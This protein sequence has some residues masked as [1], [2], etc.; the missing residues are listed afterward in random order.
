MEKILMVGAGSTKDPGYD[1]KIGETPFRDYMTERGIHVIDPIVIES[2][3]GCPDLMDRYSRQLQERVE[4]GDRVVSVL[5][6]GLLFGLPSLQATQVTF[7]IISVPLDMVSYT[8]FMVPSGHAAIAGV[9]IERKQGDVYETSQRERALKAAANMLNFEGDS[10]N[11]VGNGDLEKIA[12]KL[13]KLG[14]PIS[15][16]SDLVLNFGA[17]F[18]WDDR[19][20]YKNKVCLWADTTENLMQGSYFDR[21]QA[22]IHTSEDTLQVLGYKNLVIYAAKILSLNRPDLRKML[23]DLK[24]AKRDSYGEN[25]R[26]LE[27]ELKGMEV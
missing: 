5:Q 13:E 21:A 12:K 23:I 9:G 1:I 14:I 4:S 20:S 11:L 15:E 19:S 26:D 7:P 8:A 10:V 17:G 2:C 24:K 16:D 6:G 25:G 3:H 18:G 27:A 22:R